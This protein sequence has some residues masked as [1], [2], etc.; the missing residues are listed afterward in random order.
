MN[1][2]D[3]NLDD[4]DRAITDRLAKL[5]RKPVDTSGLKSRLDKLIDKESAALD[6]PTNT[7]IPR[8]VRWRVPLALAALIL[9]GASLAAFYWLQ[10]SSPPFEITPIDL[11]S[12]H[13]HYHEH[14]QSLTAVDN[15]GDANMQMTRQWASAPKF[16]EIEG[17]SIDACCLYDLTNCRVAC[18]H[19][20]SNGQD[21]TVVVGNARDLRLSGTQLVQA[22]GLQLAVGASGPI[23]IVSPSDP[24]RF[25][26][27][28]SRMPSDELK[29]LATNL[30]R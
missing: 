28:V 21:V 10:S 3:N 9:I 2:D 7:A 23:N 14:G 15:V 6:R 1:E 25:I 24:D 26:A 30:R 5:G 17:T 8:P 20:K 27:L 19:I 12:I 13:D 18:M 4:A 29:K 11:A 16:P 22:N